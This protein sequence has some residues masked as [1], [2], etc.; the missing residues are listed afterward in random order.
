MPWK[1]ILIIGAI[2]LFAVAMVLLLLG[3]APMHLIALLMSIGGV[4][5]F[6]GVLLP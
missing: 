6:V 2:V 5:G 4:A 1:L 3:A